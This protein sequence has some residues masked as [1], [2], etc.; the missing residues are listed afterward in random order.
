MWFLRR[1]R[2]SWRIGERRWRRAR[3][4]ILIWRII[5][6]PGN[7]HW[8]R[9]RALEYHTR[10]ANSQTIN[11]LSVRHDAFAYPCG[12]T[13]RENLSIEKRGKSIKSTI[14]ESGS[15]EIFNETQIR[16]VAPGPGK[17]KTVFR[18]AATFKDGVLMDL[19]QVML[20]PNKKPI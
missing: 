19:R 10:E 18:P 15:W 1:L 16:E 17:Q 3:R 20:F 2:V 7:F 8:L 6:V 14:G 11:L 5:P 9:H 4:L 13:F 12:N